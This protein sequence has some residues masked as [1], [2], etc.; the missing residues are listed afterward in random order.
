MCGSNRPD[1]WDNVDDGTICRQQSPITGP[2]CRCLY[3]DLEAAEQEA[4]DGARASEHSATA[5][6]Y[7]ATI[8]AAVKD[9]NDRLHPSAPLEATLVRAM[10]M[11]E[12]GDADSAA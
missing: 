10:I 12:T 5:S 11:T 2:V 4:R 3:E 9:Y 1:W 7:T 6:E 8:E